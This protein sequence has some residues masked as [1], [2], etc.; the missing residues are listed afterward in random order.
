[1]LG[2]ILVSFVRKK[3][4]EGGQEVSTDSKSPEGHNMT[5]VRHERNENLSTYMQLG[6]TNQNSSRKEINMLDL[7]APACFSGGW[8]RRNKKEHQQ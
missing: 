1:M 7:R 6:S 5:K 3:S 8:E 4:Q 2:E